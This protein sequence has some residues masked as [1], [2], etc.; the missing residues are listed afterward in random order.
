[1]YIHEEPND[2]NALEKA[3]QKAKNAEIPFILDLN[4]ITTLPSYIINKFVEIH[5]QSNSNLY[6][7]VSENSPLLEIFKRESL[8]GILSIFN[9]M[10]DLDKIL[11]QH[12][13]PYYTHY[14][15]GK[16]FEC[17]IEFQ[18]ELNRATDRNNKEFESDL[19]LE[20]RNQFQEAGITLPQKLSVIKENE[21]WL[22]FEYK[23]RRITEDEASRALY[24]VRI[25]IYG[26]KLEVCE[27]ILTVS[28]Y[29][30]LKGKEIAQEFKN[31]VKDIPNPVIF[32]DLTHCHA[33]DLNY[34]EAY[35]QCKEF[36]K[37]YIIR[38]ES[39]AT[40]ELFYLQGDT[41]YSDYEKAY[42]KA[43]SIFKKQWIISPQ[44]DEEETAKTNII[45][46]SGYITDNPDQILAFRKQF[47]DVIKKT[48]KEY[49][50][51]CIDIRELYRMES[52]ARKLFIQDITKR[53]EKL[54]IRKHNILFVA[55]LPRPDYIIHD[56]VADLYENEY[57]IVPS[58]EDAIEFH[59]SY[60]H[61]HFT[62]E[63]SLHYSMMTVDG[64]IIHE[65][66]ISI[67]RHETENMIEHALSNVFESSHV[68][69]SPQ[70]IV[71]FD[72]HSMPCVYLP[73]IQTILDADRLNLK[74]SKVLIVSQ[75]VEELIKKIVS[76]Y[77]NVRCY[78]NKEE[79]L[80]QH[81]CNILVSSPRNLSGEARTYF[82]DIFRDIY[83][84][85][86]GQ[87]T[88]FWVRF[89]YDSSR[90]SS[91]LQI[92]HYKLILLY[93]YS[94]ITPELA[95]LLKNYG[96]PILELKPTYDDWTSLLPYQLEMGC[97]AGMIKQRI[98]NLL[99]T[100]ET[101]DNNRIRYLFN[102]TQWARALESI[103]GRCLNEQ[104]MQVLNQY[105][106]IVDE[107]QYEVILTYHNYL[108]TTI[109]EQAYEN[110][111]LETLEFHPYQQWVRNFTVNYTMSSIELSQKTANET[112][113]ATAIL[114]L[115]S[116]AR[117]AQSIWDM[118][119]N[120]VKHYSK[121]RWNSCISSPNRFL[122]ISLKSVLNEVQYIL[123]EI[124]TEVEE[125][126]HANLW[127]ALDYIKNELRYDLRY[128]GIELALIVFLEMI[129][130]YSNQKSYNKNITWLRTSIEI[131][132]KDDIEVI[133]FFDKL[134]DTLE[135]TEE[136]KQK[137]N[138][139][140]EKYRIK[141]N[142]STDSDNNG[143]KYSFI[144]AKP[145]FATA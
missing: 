114:L 65:E 103:F 45:E 75:H 131:Q 58:L 124:H 110:N 31:F 56:L 80:E 144:M 70:Q 113:I 79:A 28:L 81:L 41:I 63:N 71:F 77:T 24:L 78:H 6:I 116:H 123:L 49:S 143:M 72:F 57:F 96:K 50:R 66:E 26:R 73:V 106:T 118:I 67:F 142:I 128:Q 115:Q 95:Q 119:P 145:K 94:S 30:T 64:N 83:Q 18:D 43:I 35:T 46:I 7:L 15:P 17:S 100:K 98:T 87:N 130:T 62:M 12:K 91:L 93:G 9:R 135:Y 29:G 99:W 14:F 86:E 25:D 53:V 13:T 40:N 51:I 117:F 27:R 101:M 34:V 11:N 37:I 133:L 132:E 104:N 48:L 5:S 109:L 134:G 88:Q 23:G 129:F 105:M 59:T 141:F 33:W 120:G 125:I 69:R 82:K 8:L 107:G 92:E 140:Q 10:K 112:D 3:L 60:P 76:R 2:L 68:Q 32:L 122:G 42:E 44:Y 1:M 97:H 21:D 36:K 52:D 102:G 19:S 4:S 39:L 138:H 85:P 84:T 139:Y 111:Q 126:F 127:P 47:R 22:I 74:L 90:L 54:K 121:E 108:P 16:L 89:N 20:F 38:E 55:T 137:I 61:P 136:I